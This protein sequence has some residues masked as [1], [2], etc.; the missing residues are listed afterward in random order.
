MDRIEYVDSRI[1]SCGGPAAFGNLVQEVVLQM[2]RFVR[3]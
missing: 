3:T 2:S 1:L